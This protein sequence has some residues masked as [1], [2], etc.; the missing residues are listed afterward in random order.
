M[1]DYESKPSKLIRFGVEGLRCSCRCQGVSDST[2]MKTNCKTRLNGLDENN[3]HKN[4]PMEKEP[5][6]KLVCT[7]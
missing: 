1:E 4:K 6:A 5:R 3:I 7:K 2:E